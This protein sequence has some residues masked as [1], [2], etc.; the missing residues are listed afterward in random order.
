MKFDFRNVLLVVLVGVLI[1][2]THN[3]VKLNDKVETNR[4][5]IHNLEQFADVAHENI[6]KLS[7]IVAMLSNVAFSQDE[8]ERK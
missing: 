5:N 7:E 1:V 8:T 6:E 3:V 4:K 2:L